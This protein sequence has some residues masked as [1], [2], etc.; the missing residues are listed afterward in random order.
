MK[1]YRIGIDGMQENKL[2][3]GRRIMVRLFF[4]MCSIFIVIFIPSYP[5]VLL[6]DPNASIGMILSLIL[7]FSFWVV[8]FKM[9]SNWYLHDDE[10]EK[11]L[12]NAIENEPVL[13]NT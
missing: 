7:F 2:I 6:D 3:F 4:A 9:L 1:Q 12:F 10:F 8:A 11:T 5:L 13:S